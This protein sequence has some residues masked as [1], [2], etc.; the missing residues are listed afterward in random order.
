MENKLILRNIKQTKQSKKV[1]ESKPKRI[2]QRNTTFDDVMDHNNP[3]ELLQ[4][5]QS[6]VISFLND[7]HCITN[8]KPYFE[9]VLFPKKPS[10]KKIA[11]IFV[12]LR[13][14]QEAIQLDI[15]ITTRH[16]YYLDKELF[17][18]QQEVEKIISELSKK[19]FGYPKEAFHIV[20][21]QK[22]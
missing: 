16:I 11:K 1:K 10:L 5:I 2:N 15:N 14:I 22:G 20:A 18:T 4:K 19:V 12:V 21:S 13:A 17:G 9:S 3:Q 6:T 7:I 8:N